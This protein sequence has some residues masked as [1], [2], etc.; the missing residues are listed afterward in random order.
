MPRQSLGFITAALM[1]S[2]ALAATE[3]TFVTA[4][5]PTVAGELGGLEDYSWV[6]SGF[7]LSFTVSVALFGKLSD[8]FGRRRMYLAAMSLF[9]LGS[10]LCGIARDMNELIAYRILQGAGAGGLSPLVFTIIADV[11]SFEERARVQG[12]FASVWG[13][14][15]IAG[16]V[17]GG[18]LVDRVSWRWVFLMNVPFGVLAASMLILAWK[19]DSPRSGERL[20][21]RAMAILVGGIVSL[22]LALFALER[23]GGLRSPAGWGWLATSAALWVALWRVERTADDPIVPVTLFRERLFATA[24][25]H[26]F[27]SG[28]SV[29][30]C[31]TFIPLFIQ[32]GRGV[33]ATEAGASLIPLLVPWVVSSNVGSR[34]L[35]RVDFRKLALVGAVLVVAGLAGLA[36]AGA[37]G[38]PVPFFLSSTVIGL[39]MGLSSPIFLI[40]VQTRMPRRSLGSATSTLQFCRSIGAAIGV[41]AMG[42]I[43]GAQLGEAKSLAAVDRTALAVAEHAV[44]VI[45]LLGGVAGLVATVLA[46]GGR[47]GRRAEERLDEA[48]VLGDS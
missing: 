7:M 6:F 44:F 26:A 19:D 34:M 46:P 42:A 32:L 18:F 27:A 47:L 29:F 31:M 36:I 4:A 16:P 35:L 48:I 2:L 5:M 30:G 28:A 17:I 37:S 21:V 40:A 20:D 11:Y 23:P 41:A 3:M 10:A 39:G 8:L 25:A 45:A 12:L 9:L 14:A 33:G 22:L 13:V 1:L 24:C 43:V 38:A 15:S